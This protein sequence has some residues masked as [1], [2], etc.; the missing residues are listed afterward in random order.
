MGYYTMGIKKILLFEG[1]LYQFLLFKL[2][3]LLT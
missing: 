1:N 3:T 2:L